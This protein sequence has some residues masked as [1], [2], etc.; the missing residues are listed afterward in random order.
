MVCRRDQLERPVRGADGVEVEVD[1]GRVGG[2]A[3]QRS[4]ARSCSLLNYSYDPMADLDR[5]V[6]V[7]RRVEVGVPRPYS[8]EIRQHGRIHLPHTVQAGR[9]TRKLGVC[10][11]SLCP[12]LPVAAALLTALPLHAGG[13]LQ[14]RQ[15]LYL[16]LSR[17]VV[18]GQAM[19]SL[20]QE[21]L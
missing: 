20:Q 6:V 19:V 10:S 15:R 18:V 12:P 14:V 9:T 11:A 13:L 8:A 7:V 16:A 2:G 4:S 3:I 17:T 21:N 5:V 1:L